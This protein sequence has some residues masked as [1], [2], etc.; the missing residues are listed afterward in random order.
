MTPEM[1]A[2]VATW[3]AKAAEGTLPLDE[4][5]EAILALRG[6]RKAASVS[7]E[8]AKRAKAKKEIKSADELFNELDAL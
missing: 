6:D 4:M 2:K 5:K 8:Q 7:S 1:Q 3:R